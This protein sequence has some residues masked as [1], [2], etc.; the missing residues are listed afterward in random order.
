MKTFTASFTTG[1]VSRN[2]NHEYKTA[3]VATK[4]GA[5]YWSPVFS[6]GVA[7]PV[8]PGDSDRRSAKASCYNTRE[9]A[10]FL[11]AAET[12]DRGWVSE[13]VEVSS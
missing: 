11:A 1:L 3:A 13:V 6:K 7:R 10:A 4:D 2:S 9:K 5:N 12:A 8:M